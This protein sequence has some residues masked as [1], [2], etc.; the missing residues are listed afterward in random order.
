MSKKTVQLTDHSGPRKKVGR[1]TTRSYLQGNSGGETPMSD[2][3]TNLNN[4]AK[5]GN[6][7]NFEKTTVLTGRLCRPESSSSPC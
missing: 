2:E 1:K 4:F 6:V 7:H 3:T 5:S